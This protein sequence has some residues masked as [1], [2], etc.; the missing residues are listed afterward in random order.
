[1]GRPAT[2]TVISVFFVVVVAVVRISSNHPVRYAHIVRSE[3]TWRRAVRR[4]CTR[5]GAS[6][7][8]R[9]VGRTVGLS[10]VGRPVGCPGQSLNDAPPAA[11][12]YRCTSCGES[13]ALRIGGGAGPSFQPL[14]RAHT[15]KASAGAHVLPLDRGRWPETFWFGGP[16]AVA[17]PPFC[18]DRRRSPPRGE[19]VRA[20]D[21]LT[22]VQTTV[23]KPSNLSK[24]AY[25][26]RIVPNIQE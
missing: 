15:V 19:R 24:C 1:V 22:M 3:V 26:S 9:S 17:R 7:V 11:R 14:R 13:A 6:P 20:Q 21:V 2:K 8:G 12:T 23:A 25:T 18:P 16:R 4:D 5:D 10:S